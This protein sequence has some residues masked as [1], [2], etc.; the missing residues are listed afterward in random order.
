MAS[1]YSHVQIKEGATPGLPRII[2]SWSPKIEIPMIG[3]AYN[4][5]DTGLLMPGVIVT[6]VYQSIADTI[7]GI[8][9]IATCLS[10][11]EVKDAVVI[12]FSLK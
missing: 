1:G 5:A 9:L 11:D 4:R 3:F 7:E 8:L 6:S 10:E 2:A 12:Y